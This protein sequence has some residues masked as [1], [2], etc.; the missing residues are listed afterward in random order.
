MEEQG[1]MTEG[2]SKGTL[3]VSGEGPGES[4]VKQR[5]FSG[6]RKGEA[7][8]GLL[9]GEDLELLSRTLCV[10]A[11]HL[12]EWR[13]TFLTAGCAAMKSRSRDERDER[14]LRLQAKLGEATLDNELL[15]EKITHLEAGRPLGRQRSRR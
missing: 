14:I 15:R 6:K 8:L 9:R 10:P 1:G 13:E 11:A 5:R 7:V 2:A 12:S 4:V 3:R